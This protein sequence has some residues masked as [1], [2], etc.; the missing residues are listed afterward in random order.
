MKKIRLTW[1]ATS[2]EQSE[3]QSMMWRL[4]L[5][6]F[7]AMLS[8]FAVKTIFDLLF[9]KDPTLTS[10]RFVIYFPIILISFA[11]RVMK[12]SWKA[13]SIEAAIMSIIVSGVVIGLMRAFNYVK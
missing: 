11:P 4:W 2:E 8:L 13:I 9:G 12:R 5:V 7:I 1:R 3:N 10:D 6:F